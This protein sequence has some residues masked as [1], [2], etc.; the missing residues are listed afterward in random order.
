MVRNKSK[1]GHTPKS[2]RVVLVYLWKTNEYEFSKK[3]E[4]IG[5]FSQKMR[6]LNGGVRIKK[7]DNDFCCD[8]API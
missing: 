6:I 5:I 8:M 7:G 4:K 2:G 1:K 3:W